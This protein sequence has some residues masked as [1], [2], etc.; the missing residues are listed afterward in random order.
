MN[1]ALDIIILVILITS[2]ITSTKKGFFKTLMSLVCLI[3]TV[4]II[5]IYAQPFGALI[6]QKIA[7][8]VIAD[9]VISENEANATDRA[10][11]AN[12]EA[13]LSGKLMNKLFKNEVP[14]YSQEDKAGATIKEFLVKLILE[15]SLLSTICSGIAS[16]IIAV[17]IRIAVIIIEKIIGPILKLPL[18]RE[19]NKGLG[20]VIGAINAVLLIWIL[21]IVVNLLSSGYT[22]KE[23]NGSF[24]SEVIAH[25]YVY[26]YAEEYNPINKIFL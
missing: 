19:A 18:L 26:K 16:I 6:N 24:E 22:P 10:E 15:S 7:A 2:I 14:E 5:Y 17:V 9:M 4:V 25:T 12:D 3:G 8:P 1:I 23:E 21:C 11:D 20:A 13:L